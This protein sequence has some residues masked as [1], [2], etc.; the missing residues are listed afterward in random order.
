ML[1]YFLDSEH[2]TDKE[3]LSGDDI[4]EDYYKYIGCNLKDPIRSI[5]DHWREHAVANPIPTRKYKQTALELAKARDFLTLSYLLTL[6]LPSMSQTSTPPPAQAT[7]LQATVNAPSRVSTHTAAPVP[8]QPTSE[9]STEST[10]AVE[11]KKG[12]SEPQLRR[13]K[14]TRVLERQPATHQLPSSVIQQSNDTLSSSSNQTTA[15]T[16]VQMAPQPEASAHG[17][18]TKPQLGR[19]KSM[20]LMARQQEAATSGSAEDEF[21]SHKAPE[22][23]VIPLK[24]IP[25]K[26]ETAS[27]GTLGSSI[28]TEVRNIADSEGHLLRKLEAVTDTERDVI[29]A[30]PGRSHVLSRKLEVPTARR[31]DDET[32]TGVLVK[33]LVGLKSLLKK[34]TA[35]S[36]DDKASSGDAAVGIAARE[37]T[38][39]S[40]MAINTLVE[41]HRLTRQVSSTENDASKPVDLNH[42]RRALPRRKSIAF[43]VDKNGS[44]MSDLIVVSDLDSPMPAAPTATAATTAHPSIAFN[45]FNAATAVVQKSPDVAPHPA[46]QGNKENDPPAIAYTRSGLRKNRKS[47]LYDK[48]PVRKS[49]TYP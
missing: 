41:E 2:L 38:P 26:R 32:A 15:Q 37:E 18:V 35:T 34:L 16:Q 23:P 39:A 31:A 6:P 48:P 27:A 43:A 11:S 25:K 5:R 29:T 21:T 3:N 10:L 19:R 14:S 22:K 9:L 12:G 44:P 17:T 28:D 20:R 13:R 33:S 1:S 30:Q 46:M 36:E 24:G 42:S 4:L 40:S 47:I 45:A 8:P 7:N 49:L